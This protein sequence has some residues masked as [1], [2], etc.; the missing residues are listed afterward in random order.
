MWKKLDKGRG[1]RITQG[2]IKGRRLVKEVL[3][4]MAILF[5]SYLLAMFLRYRVFKSEPGINPFSSQYVAIAFVYS[6]V[7]ASTFEYTE[8]PRWLPSKAN[9]NG[10]YRLLTKNAIGCLFMLAF[11]YVAGVIHFSRW[12]LFLFWI[13]SSMGLLIRRE[14]IYTFTIWKRLQGGD[15]VHVLLIGDGFLA[16]RYL[17][18]IRSNPQ[19]GIRILGY[20]GTSDRLQ[21]DLTGV[22]DPEEL[23]EEDIPW[24]GEE[25]TEELVKDVDEIVIAK[26]N[27]EDEE[28]IKILKLTDEKGILT[29][30]VVRC[31]SLVRS[32]SRIRDL[33]ESKEILLNDEPEDPLGTIPVTGMVITMAMLLLIL[34][35]N[36]G[37]GALSSDV[38]TIE[39]Y[40]NVIFG[41]F[42]FFLFLDTKE[43]SVLR[44]VG[45]SWVVT[46][47]LAIAYEI[48]YGG[49][50]LFD[51]GMDLLLV[52]VVL[53]VCLLGF[54][55]AEFIG[56]EEIIFWD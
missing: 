22:Y 47:L 39:S 12:A 8:I 7:I 29:H 50:V 23:D 25:L 14:I 42:A 11:F 44:R 36:F 41:L 52:S 17:Q 15:Q 56:K 13:F 48:F 31:G 54:G 2:P 6:L 16:E 40:R 38:G 18:S 19:F 10:M 20:I 26:G 27:L 34:I 43:K 24:L 49:R 9:I 4:N 55:I 5:A 33:G 53:F 37:I 1:D 30:M 32:D 21:R 45:F 51:M 35:S 46:A 28:A 3:I